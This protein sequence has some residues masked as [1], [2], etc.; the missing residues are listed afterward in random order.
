MS[1]KTK[2]YWKGYK[3]YTLT[4]GTKFYARDDNDANLYRE[5]VGDKSW[6]QFIKI[7]NQNWKKFVR[8]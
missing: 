5:K 7:Q 3:T 2:T 4:D 1:K 8:L 6:N